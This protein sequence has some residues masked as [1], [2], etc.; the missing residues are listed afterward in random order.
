MESNIRYF[1]SV[2]NINM[3]KYNVSV[4]TKKVV[5]KIEQR[6]LIGVEVKALANQI[7]RLVHDSIPQN[8]TEGLTCM[9]GWIIGYL[10][11]HEAKD[12]FQKDLEAEFNIRRSTATGILQLM[13]KNGLITREPVSYDA[14]LKKLIL[15][16]KAKEICSRINHR[17]DRIENQ[18][19]KGLTQQELD[20]FFEIIDK[21]KKNTR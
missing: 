21:I 14:R 4:L 8:D 20:A 19:T 1:T 11:M 15:T 5:R 13:E 16:P 12:I 3:R 17:I 2:D 6:R 18:V 9:Q 7:K 10:S